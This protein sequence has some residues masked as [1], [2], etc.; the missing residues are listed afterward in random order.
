MKPTR[1]ILPAILVSAFTFTMCDYVTD[2]HDVDQSVAVFDT[3]KRVAIIEEWTGHTCISCPAAARDIEMLDS[4][5]DQ[6]FIAISIHDDYF[7]EPCPPHPL[8]PCAA[9]HPGAFAE[10]FR[11][12]TGLSY[13][14]EHP[15]GPSSP[16]QGMVNR[17]GTQSGTEVRTRGAWP[18]LV[19]S[20]VQEDA[21]ASMHITHQ[22]NAS[23]RQLGVTVWGTWL[24]AYTGNIS[25]AIMLTESGMIGWQTDGPSACDSVFEF[26]HV[27]RECLNTPGSIAGS[28]LTSGTTAPGTVYSFSLAS[29]YT[30]P[31]AFDASHCHIIAMIFD[32]TT[33][34]VLQ[35]WEED[36]L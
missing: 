11:C 18:G 33:G 25:V 34:E 24:Q 8:P 7:A 22:Y 13:S 28:P 9:G 4:I 5:Y 27:L 14:L 36:V 20:L 16:P 17:L 1:F 32:T 12:P 35:A 3:T 10:D 31:V 2:P 15:I 26:N 19:D 30:I 23:S 6:S 29:P 21:C